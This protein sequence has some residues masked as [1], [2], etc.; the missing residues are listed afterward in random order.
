MGR[1]DSAFTDSARLL[2]RGAALAC[3]IAAGLFF[4][5]GCGQ[6]APPRATVYPVQGKVELNGKPT[7]GAVVT[8]HPKGG[9]D[10]PGTGRGKARRH[11]R[12]RHLRSQRWRGRRGLHRHGG[13]VQTGPETG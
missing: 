9:T 2:G 13:M 7:A 4:S 12:R 1:V 3:G 5:A 11:V 8:L 10:A 6:S